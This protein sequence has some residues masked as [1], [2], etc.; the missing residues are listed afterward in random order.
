MN[1]PVG[2]TRYERRRGGKRERVREKRGGE[3]EMN[4][5]SFLSYSKEK[6]GLRAGESSG[7]NVTNFTPL[8]AN[9]RLVN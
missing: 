6:P 9:E 2:E 3:G 4:G 5:K 7:E 8:T 1:F